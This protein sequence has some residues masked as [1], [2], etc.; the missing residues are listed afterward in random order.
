MT[1][2]GDGL[3]PATVAALQLADSAFPSGLF[4]QSMG[5]EGYVQAG[6]VRDVEG[7]RRLVRN[8]L[9]AQVAPLDGTACAL[10]WQDASAGDVAGLA[11]L[12]RQVEARKLGREQREASARSGGRVLALATDLWPSPVLRALAGQVRAGECAPHH[13][14]VSGALAF[15]QGVP[16]V[17]A[18]VIELYVVATAMVGAA[19]RLLPFDHRDAQAGLTDLR[20]DLVRLARWAVRRRREE[21]GGF[22][23]LADVMS[24][25][26]EHGPIRLFGT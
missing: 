4:T 18:V 12:C 2:D 5:L 14:V 23:P 6:R 24:M 15:T 16:Q 26:H 20:G 22:A 17:T 21:L 1:P 7:V 11:D 8:V 25:H 19:M 9:E 10:A 13:C 3:S